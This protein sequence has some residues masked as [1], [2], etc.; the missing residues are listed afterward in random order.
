[1]S[2][3]LRGNRLDHTNSI[4]DVIRLRDL[5][6]VTT[7]LFATSIIT[8]ILV[9]VAIVID[10]TLKFFS[11]ILSLHLSQSIAYILRNIEPLVLFKRYNK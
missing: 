1:M 3:H 5:S 4:R 11:L 8:S 2:N 6:L 7:K 10:C 9:H